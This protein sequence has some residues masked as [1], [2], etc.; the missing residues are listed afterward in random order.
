MIRQWPEW[1]YQWA[2]LLN[3][4]SALHGLMTPFYIGR[5]R[6]VLD[7]IFPVQVAAGR[8]ARSHDH[9]H[10]EAHLCLTGS[11]HYTLTRAYDLTPGSVILQ[12]PGIPHDWTAGDAGFSCLFFWFSLQPAATLG[13]L[14]HWPCLPELLWDLAFILEESRRMLPGWHHRAALRLSLILS[15]IILVAESIH[16]DAAQPE[17]THSLPFCVEL[18]LQ[19]H[20]AQPI[21][22][23]DIAD[24]LQMSERHL[25]RTFARHT[26]ETI[27]AR[28]LR[29]RLDKIC[30]LLQNTTLSL[31]EIGRHAGMPNRSYLCRM[32]HH[33]FG[34]TPMTYRAQAQGAPATP[35]A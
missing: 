27:G 2:E 24:S 23:Q 17:A 12:A 21:R 7:L 8:G 29:M 16:F 14:R 25:M 31:A 28:L 10:Y 15:R 20:L 19:E 30:A 18:Y 9:P 4:I 33:A 13:E 32:F 1:P 26:G 5:H 35:E 3:V 22:I 34:M 11:A 6:V